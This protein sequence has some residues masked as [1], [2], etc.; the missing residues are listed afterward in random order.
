MKRIKSFKLFES[1]NPINTNI[2][3]LDPEFVK[4]ITEICIS[5]FDDLDITPE[6]ED[7]RGHV[8]FL[9]PYFR[10]KCGENDPDYPSIQIN[11]PIYYGH[12]GYNF[13]EVEGTLLRIKNYLGDS[14]I[15][16]GF[17]YYGKYNTILLGRK[18]NWDFKG[19]RYQII[20]NPKDFEI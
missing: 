14:Y 15:S 18:Y 5:L 17:S 2:S 1:I 4:D 3:K 13:S 12:D 11:L 7:D 8:S 9:S 20:Y 19:Y 6:D 16:C 10:T